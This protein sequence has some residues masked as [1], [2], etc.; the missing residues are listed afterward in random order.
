MAIS[1]YCLMPDHLHA[2]AAVESADGDFREFVRIAKQRTAFAY[3]QQHNAVLWQPSFF[4]RTLREGQDLGPV[5]GY[6]IANPVR[7]GL[8]SR[9]N[10]YAHWGSS[11]YSRSELLEF[12]ARESFGQT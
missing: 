10:D 9:V 8:V 11:T 7:A 1:A 4:D 5:L 3:R 12:V 2:V 6:V